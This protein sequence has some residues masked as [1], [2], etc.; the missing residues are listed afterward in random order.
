MSISAPGLSPEQ[1][2]ELKYARLFAVDF[3][4]RNQGWTG[5]SGMPFWSAWLQDG[6]SLYT[7]LEDT[8]YCFPLGLLIDANYD[9]IWILSGAIDDYPNMLMG[10]Y[11][12]VI[13]EDRPGTRLYE[14]GLTHVE[15]IE[16]TYNLHMF[17]INP[18]DNLILPES[19][20]VLGFHNQPVSAFVLYGHSII[21]VS[22][23]QRLIR[24]GL[25]FAYQSTNDWTSGPVPESFDDTAWARTP[26]GLVPGIMLGN[27]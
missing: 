18:L 8:L 4:A 24:M 6:E 19:W 17:N 2:D 26:I 22:Q 25:S 21:T 5:L 10:I 1:V 14:S 12:N 15:T 23:E 7:M 11:D 16:G 9:Q 20:L 3:I 27:G 13:D